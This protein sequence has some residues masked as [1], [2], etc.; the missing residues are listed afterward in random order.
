MKPFTAHNTGFGLPNCR[1]F[2]VEITTHNGPSFYLK[3]GAECEGDA[4]VH[5]ADV[6]KFSVVE[7]G[8]ATRVRVRECGQFE[9]VLA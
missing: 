2:K 7:H 1:Y 3:V 8:G 5:A 4:R 6:P 9:A